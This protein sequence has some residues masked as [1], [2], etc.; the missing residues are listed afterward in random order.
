LKLNQ[1]NS[2]SFKTLALVLLLS[3]AAIF[4]N[5][6]GYKMLLQPL[7]I[8]GQVFENKFTTELFS[9]STREFWQKEAWMAIVWLIIFAALLINISLKNKKDLKQLFT[10]IPLAY[11]I[12][13]VAFIYL[14]STAFRNIIFLILVL[15]PAE[16]LLLFNFIEKQKKIIPALS[17]IAVVLSITFYVFIVSNKY[18]ELTDSRDRYGLEVRPDYNAVG[19]SDFVINNKLSG[20]CFSDYLISSYIRLLLMS[21]IYYICH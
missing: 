11:M 16:F 17:V 18:Y 1:V 19:A 20:K 9:I 7:A 3:V 4:I 14:S 15:F 13:V 2:T 12:V 10:R 6:Y 21:Y 5:P 8:F